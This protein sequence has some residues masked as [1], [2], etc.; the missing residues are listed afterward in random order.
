MVNTEGFAAYI[1]L[2]EKYS[3]IVG[4]TVLINDI[5][6]LSTDSAII[7]KDA[8]VDNEFSDGIKK[9]LPGL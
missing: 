2:S 7:T 1:E 4:K 6:G 9:A 3:D 5:G 8:Q